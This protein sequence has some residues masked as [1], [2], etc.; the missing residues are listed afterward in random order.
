M[1]R[2]KHVSIL[3]F[4]DYMTLGTLLIVFGGIAAA[5]CIKCMGGMNIEFSEGSRSGVIQK[6]SKKGMI[7]KTWEGELNLGYTEA[8][9]D[10]NGH[11]SIRP[12][13]FFFSVSDDAVAERLK[14]AEIGGK[15]VTLDY[16]QYFLRGWDKGGT[17]Y[18]VVD[19]V[20]ASSLLS[21]K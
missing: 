18:D 8:S 6:L 16:K 9:T 12:A 3:T 11:Q 21:E 13:M 15:R 1:A 4:K 2:M 10:S 5:F 14:K 20:D 7:W 17:S 19:V